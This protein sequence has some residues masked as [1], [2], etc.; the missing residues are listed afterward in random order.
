MREIGDVRWSICAD[1]DGELGLEFPGAL[2]VDRGP[3]AFFE[4]LEGIYVGLI[5]GGD[6]GGVDVDRPTLEVSILSE[7]G[8]LA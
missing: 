6:D 7:G 1:L 8:A 5:L 4:G 3:G 2:V